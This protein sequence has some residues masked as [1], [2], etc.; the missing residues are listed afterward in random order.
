MGKLINIHQLKEFVFDGMSIMV[1][2]F[3]AVG[4]PE[5]LIDELVK[6][7]VK[8]LTII[9]NDAGFIDKGVGKLITNGQVKKLVASHIGLNPM[10]GQLMSDE[11]ME[12]QLVPQGTLAEQIRAGGSGL[13]GILTPT[14]IGTVMEKGKQIISLE[15]KKFILEPSMKADLALIYGSEV[16]KYG[17]TKYTKTTQNFNPVMATATKHVIVLARKL[18]EEMNPDHVLTPHIFIDNIIVEVQN[19]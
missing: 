19:G 14:G 7:N 9:C 17:N 16:D 15:G 13:G 3:M 12:V 6:I 5:A 10:A 18:V 1:G 8:E 4:T 11:K 2:G